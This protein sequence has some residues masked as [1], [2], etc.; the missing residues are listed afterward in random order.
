MTQEQIEK[1]VSLVHD[2]RYGGLPTHF[3]SLTAWNIAPLSREEQSMLWTESLRENPQREAGIYLNIPFCRKKCAF[4]FLDVKGG[5][6]YEEQE[7]YI[8]AAE[9]EMAFFAPV[10][11]EKEI[12]CVYIGGG[13]PNFLPASLL[14]RILISLKHYFRI[15][16]GAQISME[17]NPDFFDEEKAVAVAECGVSMLLM[18]IQSFSATVNRDNGRA[19]DVTRIKDAFDLVRRA[20]I[21]HINADL[22]C[23]LKGQTKKD[24]I[25]DVLLLSRLRPTQ[26]HLNRIKPLA[27]TLPPEIKKELSSWQQAGLEILRRAG[28]TVLDEESACLDGIRNQQG[29]YIFHLDN[30]L[31]GLGSGA[32]SHAWGRLRS[33]NIVSPAEYSESALSGGAFSQLY[34]KTG[35]E[36]ELIH[37]LMNTL[38]HGVTVM[39]EEVRE[40][41]GAAGEEFFR[42]K[43]A[44][45]AC[46]GYIEE[47]DGGWKCEMRMQD[48]L[49]VTAALYGEEMLERIIRR[50]GL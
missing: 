37:Y 5:S 26:I 28:Y 48:W 15:K 23:G 41:F 17:S 30:S 19:Q 24:F 33:R 36:E 32:M 20:G 46:R 34:M 21:K 25:R 3:P 1:A 9:K 44:D 27:G 43:A 7:K 29:N 8:L 42:R 22:L 50:N 38:L 14:K 12:S 11:A 39:P 6:V 31:L 35:I 40:K 45:M 49:G 13:T 47:S 16:P 18:G 2:V 10:F 4:C